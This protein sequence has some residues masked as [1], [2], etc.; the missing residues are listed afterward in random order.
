MQNILVFL[1]NSVGLIITVVIITAGLILW[2][3]AE[4]IVDM[5]NRQAAMQAEFMQNEIYSAY[6][7]QIVSG[8]QII[9]AYRRYSMQDAFYLYI[10]TNNGGTIRNFG[11]QPNGSTQP[12]PNFDYNNGALASGSTTCNITIDQIQDNASVYY[13]SPQS[14]FSAKLIKD[15]NKRVTAIFFKQK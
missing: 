7:N 10:Q 6:D 1:K 13:I 12:C 11:M 8:S 2:S 4:P 15:A 3:K 9:T 5:T 14:R